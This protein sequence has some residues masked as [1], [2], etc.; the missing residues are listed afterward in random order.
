MEKY[1]YYASSA[2]YKLYY[3][4]VKETQFRLLSTLLIFLLP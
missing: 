3:F 1:N 2:E 4:L